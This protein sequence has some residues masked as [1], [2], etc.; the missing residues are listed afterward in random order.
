VEA[1][2]QTEV[3]ETIG[4]ITKMESLDSFEEDV[5]PNS[6]VLKNTDPFPGY[7]AKISGANQDKPRSIFIILRYRY[8]PEKIN[9]INRDMMASRITDCHPSFG[10]IITRESILPCIRI[11][12]IKDYS[13]IP[14][15]QN[16]Y[17]RNDLKLMDYKHFN[18]PA[19]IKIFKAFRLTEIAEGLY[20]DLN[21]GEKIYIH[22]P[23]AINWKRFDHI[24]KKIKYHINNPNFDAALGV[25][26]RF[27]G[28]E[29]VIRIY[30]QEKTLERA[31]QLRK[32]F[33]KE[34]KSDLLISA[35]LDPSE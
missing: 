27:C 35:S 2:K 18:G 34:V 29:D 16:F 32:I 9:H 13:L 6:M 4:S 22:I 12:Y 5:L 3:I 31:I 10:E 30:D 15:I 20:R 1:M 14:V 19:R 25:I 11:K 21:D 7:R 26:Y 33:V 28:P 23:H 8:A 17:K 24:T